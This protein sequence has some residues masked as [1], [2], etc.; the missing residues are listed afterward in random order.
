MI[1]HEELIK[2][3]LQALTIEINES[4]I[5]LINIYGS[6]NDDILVFD[7]LE[8]FININID[9]SIIIGGDFNTVIDIE[10]RKMEVKS[11]N[12]RVGQKY[13]NL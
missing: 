10:I 5:M 4:E 9:K 13:K 8:Q 6:N 7:M 11:Q 2:G 1:K 12:K 3:R